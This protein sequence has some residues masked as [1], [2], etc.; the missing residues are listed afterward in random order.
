M[1]YLS[2]SLRSINNKQLRKPQSHLIQLVK[3]I[4]LCQWKAKNWVFQRPAHRKNE[5]LWFYLAAVLEALWLK[6]TQNHQSHLEDEQKQRQQIWLKMCD[7]FL[8]SYIFQNKI[9]WTLVYKTVPS[10]SQ[11]LCYRLFLHLVGAIFFTTTDMGS[12]W[13]SKICNHLTYSFITK[14]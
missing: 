6:K 2:A 13:G 3:V 5:W 1:K 4:C 14:H 12:K 9:W 7:F 10:L 11:S 8:S